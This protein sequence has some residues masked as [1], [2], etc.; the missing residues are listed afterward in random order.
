MET[1]VDAVLTRR[2]LLRN[3]ALVALYAW[4][5][6]DAHSMA[7]PALAGLGVDA[8]VIDAGLPEATTLARGAREHARV[9]MLDDD[10]A[11]LFYGRLGPTWRERGI[12]GLA[13][14]PRAPAL[15]LLEPL[16]HEY[17][18]RTVGLE[19][20]PSTGA[21]VLT[22]LPHRRSRRPAIAEQIR[23]ALLEEDDA[24]FAWYMAASRPPMRTDV[25]V[26]QI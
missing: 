4:A 22:T 20:A 1:R 19:R 8:V 14:L 2:T 12:R 15:F 13:G 23:Q 11:E 5:V 3:S 25:A 21:A 6:R 26:I 18:L 10:V 9:E 16:A 7:P 24:V 17:G